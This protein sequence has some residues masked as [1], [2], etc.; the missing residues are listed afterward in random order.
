[1]L[2]FASV[3]V[4]AQ[5]PNRNQAVDA[6][7]HYV[8]YCNETIHALWRTHQD[9]RGLNESANAYLVYGPKGM[10]H[11]DNNDYLTRP[12]YYAT[13]PAE[14]YSKCLK[15]AKP[16]STTLTGKTPAAWR[17]SCVPSTA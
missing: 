5:V 15:S 2:V 14:I 8:D 4:V 16:C 17:H 1:M 13:P 12:E 11:F 3:C 7:N 6:L 9:W 10:S